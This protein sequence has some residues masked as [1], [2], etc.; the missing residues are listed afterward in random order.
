MPSAGDA[1]GD[2]EVDHYHQM[3]H[4][5]AM[6]DKETKDLTLP[7]LDINLQNKGAKDAKYLKLLSTVKQELSDRKLDLYQYLHAYWDKCTDWSLGNS[8]VMLG[9]RRVIPRHTVLAHLHA[10]YQGEHKP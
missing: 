9:Q 7:D 1:H 4:Q 8:I 10:T 2:S 3:L 6:E 5:V